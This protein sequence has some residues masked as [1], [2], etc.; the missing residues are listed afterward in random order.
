MTTEFPAVDAVHEPGQ[1]QE[2]RLP[3]RVRAC[4]TAPETAPADAH[5]A[6]WLEEDGGVWAD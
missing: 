3:D 6:V 2:A 5:A 4:V 1:R